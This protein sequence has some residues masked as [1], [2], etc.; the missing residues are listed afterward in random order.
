VN[1]LFGI[2]MATILLGCLIAIAIVVGIVAVFAMR[3]R[4]F[5][6]LATRSARRRLGRSA[7]IVAGLMLGTTIIAAA[8]STGD[9]MTHTIRSETLDALGNIDEV[10]ATRGAEF[11]ATIFIDS[12]GDIEYFSEALF[13]SVEAAAAQSE[14]IDGI[15]PAITEFVGVQDL[16][17]QQT[18]PRVTIFAPD[19]ERRR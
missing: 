5:L 9:T 11:G 8:F 18:E 6:R 19:P 3:S 10:V 4:V 13:E 7:L 12:P 1:N 14:H 2:P 17:S 15:T 16:T